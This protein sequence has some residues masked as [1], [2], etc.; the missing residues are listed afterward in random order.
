MRILFVAPHINPFDPPM[1]GDSQRTQ[2]L[3][4]SCLA[5]GDVDVAMFSRAE[6]TMGMDVR[7]VF[8]DKVKP[9]VVKVGKAAKWLNLLKFW[10]VEALFPVDK[11]RERV[12]DTLVAANQYDLIVC[13]YFYRAVACGLWK[14]H[15]RL[16]VDFD[17]ALPF[18][19]L[20]QIK[21]TSK[22]STKTRMRIAA[23]EAI[24]I[25]AQA[26][27]RMRHSFF[28]NAN[29]VPRLNSSFLPNLPFYQNSCG[30]TIFKGSEPR[31]LFVGQVDYGPNQRGLDHFIEHIYVPLLQ[32][33]P[34]L[35][36]SVVGRCDNLQLRERWESYQGVEVKGYVD[37]LTA[38]YESCRVVVI[39]VY[40]CGGTNIKLLEA[41]QMN[42]ACVATAEAA[43]PLGSMF[44]FGDDLYV[45][46]NDQE[47]S[48]QV[49]RLLTD[50]AENL[51]VAG[52]ALNKM[53]R[54]FSFDAFCQIVSN[55][56]TKQ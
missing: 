36:L 32:R 40:Q 19:F 23:K 25:T 13:R 16:V 28:S 26:T 8:A 4:R 48:N 50:E 7:I 20:E 5:L 37:D 49:F 17:D 41:M 1:N 44:S 38:E 43:K 11:N 31:L 14:Y 12:L 33:K 56:L 30:K 54:Y 27:R 2:L 18:Y 52:N 39:P 15:E 9:D 6:S 51:R 55:A 35:R 42:R 24:R 53:N 45:A 10:D 29:A 3:L 46:A 47:F 22:W 21:P 34:D